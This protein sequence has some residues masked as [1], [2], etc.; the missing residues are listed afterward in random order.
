MLFKK[1][2]KKLNRKPS[3]MYLEKG[4]ELYN[5]SMKAWLEKK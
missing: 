2:I 1:K 5:R 4:S 3:K